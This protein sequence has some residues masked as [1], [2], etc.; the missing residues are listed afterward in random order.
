MNFFTFNVNHFYKKV[1]L[2]FCV[3]TLTACQSKMAIDGKKH[4]TAG[5]KW[6]ALAQYS[7]S[8]LDQYG[9]KITTSLSVD[10][11]DSAIN[12]ILGD[13]RLSNKE[14]NFTINLLAP[15]FENKYI[16]TPICVQLVEYSK[17]SDNDSSTLLSKYFSKHEFELFKFYSDLFILEDQLKLLAQINNELLDDYLLWLSRNNISMKTFS[18][19]TQFFSNKLTEKSFESYIREPNRQGDVAPNMFTENLDKKSQGL[20]VTEEQ[21]WS[22]KKFNSPEDD[23]SDKPFNSPEAIWLKKEGNNEIKYLSPDDLWTIKTNLLQEKLSL[24][25]ANKHNLWLEL[26]KIPLKT[27][28]VACTFQDNYF[29]VVDSISSQQVTIAIRGQSK[30]IT[31]GVI[32][33]VDSG[34]L[35]KSNSIVSFI[36]KNESIVFSIHDVTRCFIE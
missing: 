11:R 19:F 36:P 32:F 3:L 14:T 1:I 27:G 30:K 16:C 18:E 5:E 10:E 26:K 35:F 9:I 20:F 7:S 21:H 6:V 8:T 17:F 23:W 2:F 31:D 22:N 4:Q 28:D 13:I 25:K 24:T 29:G 33:D 12:F 34:E 15:S